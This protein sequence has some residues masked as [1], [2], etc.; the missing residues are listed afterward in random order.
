MQAGVTAEIIEEYPLDRYGP[1]C[2]L[3]G[4]TETGRPLHIVASAADGPEVKVI[5]LYEPDPQAWADFRTR[6]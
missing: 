1:S 2:L 4:F 3:L 6:R 5:T